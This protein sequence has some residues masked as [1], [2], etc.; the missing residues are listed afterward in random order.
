MPIIITPLRA[1]GHPTG[2]VIR[3]ISRDY[4]LRPGGKKRLRLSRE[5]VEVEVGRE[6][7]RIMV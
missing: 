7:K 5:K 2:S 6:K 4:F 1:S 3:Q